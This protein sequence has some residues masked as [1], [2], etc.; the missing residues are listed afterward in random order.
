[1]NL[2]NQAAG[3]RFLEDLCLGPQLDE[4][5]TQAS[6]FEDRLPSVGTLGPVPC[7]CSSPDLPVANGKMRIGVKIAW[8]K[9]TRS[10]ELR[11]DSE[12]SRILALRFK[13]NQSI[14][15]ARST[16]SNQTRRINL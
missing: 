6:F 12:T 11:L 14:V 5:A 4:S 7:V 16:I 15:T 3:R 13:R 1:M 2:P 10:G 9:A 8:S